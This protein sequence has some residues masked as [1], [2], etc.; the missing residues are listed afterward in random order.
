MEKPIGWFFDET[1]VN[2]KLLGYSINGLNC[3][4]VG[5]FFYWLPVRA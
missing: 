4:D 5:S 3:V 1:S 2:Q